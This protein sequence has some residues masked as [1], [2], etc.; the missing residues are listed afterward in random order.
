MADPGLGG[1][2][3][4]SRG[5]TRH[6]ASSRP[7]PVSGFTTSSVWV[8]LDQNRRKATQTI[9]CY[10]PDLGRGFLRL[11]TPTCWRN[12]TNSSPVMSRAEEAGEPPEE[13]QKQAEASGKST[14]LA[15]MA[16]NVQFGC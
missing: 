9:R 10:R 16:W 6:D 5:E 15:I 11:S 8:H 14:M 4:S 13:I 12:A 7:S 2:D 3:T 1:K